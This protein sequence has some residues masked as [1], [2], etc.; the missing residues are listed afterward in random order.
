MNIDHNKAK[1][2]ITMKSLFC[3]EK[4][5]SL[6]SCVPVNTTSQVRFTVTSRTWQLLANAFLDIACAPLSVVGAGVGC[7][8]SHW[9]IVDAFDVQVAEDSIRRYII[10][11]KSDANPL[12]SRNF[13][14]DSA[15]A[16][17]ARARAFVIPVNGKFE[18]GSEQNFHSRKKV[19]WIIKNIVSS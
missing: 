12:L 17:F 8:A 11:R 1:N 3:S 14:F 19:E 10:V 15:F 6:L 5:E 7:G 13:L 4:E 9:P 18:F 16:T 2:L